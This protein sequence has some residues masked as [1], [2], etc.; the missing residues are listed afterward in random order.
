[1][2]REL[3]TTSLF[4]EQKGKMP[5]S[6]KFEY[7]QTVHVVAFAPSSL[8]PGTNVAV[9]GIT[10]L[11]KERKVFDTVYPAGTDVYLIEYADGKS[12][13]S[14]EEYLEPAKESDTTVRSPTKK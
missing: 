3:E 12:V 7:G 11:S 4:P 9:V 5:K 2:C 10:R 6:F 14:P 13:E 8:R 1:M